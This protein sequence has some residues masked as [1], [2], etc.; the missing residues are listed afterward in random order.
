MSTTR[1]PR[2]RNTEMMMKLRNRSIP[3][4]SGPG[5]PTTAPRTGQGGGGK[6]A[7]GEETKLKLQKE[8]FTCGTWNVRTLNGDGKLEQ[9]EYEMTKYKWNVLGI[10]EMRWTGSGEML[11]EGHKVWFSGKEKKHEEGVGFLVHKNTVKAVVECEPIS[12]RMIRIQIAASPRNVAII[13]VYAPTSDCKDEEIDA[14]YDTLGST[15]RKIPKKDIK[16]IQ[17]DWNA[18]IGTDS[19]EDWHGTVEKFAHGMTNDRGERL[20]EFC[21][22]NNLTVANTLGDHKNSRRITWT[23]PDGRTRNQIDYIL[24]ETKCKTCIRPN[25]TRAFPGCDI[26]SDHNLVMMTMKVK[27]RMIKKQRAVRVKYNLDLLKT[28]SKK[29]NEY[30]VKISNRFAPLMELEDVQKMADQ[31]TEVT[32][33]TALEVLGRRRVMKQP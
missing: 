8:E 20:L 12:S 23:S 17:G 7:T 5:I 21:K 25:K 13:Q 16:I 6:Y 29:R 27:L 4:R 31:F 19:Y 11:T 32:N 22:L 28:D 33:E 14:F 3:D 24:V 2:S 1:I 10:A 15:L 26:G 18:K 30:A 9:L